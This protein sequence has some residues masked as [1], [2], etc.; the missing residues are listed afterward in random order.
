MKPTSF[1]EG[2][3]ADHITPWSAFTMRLATWLKRT[4]AQRF[5]RVLV[6]SSRNK[7]RKHAV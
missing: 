6:T 1:L 2:I 5:P 7:V 3:D 4:N